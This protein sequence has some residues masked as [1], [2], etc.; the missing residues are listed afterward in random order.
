MLAVVLLYLLPL[1]GLSLASNF[2]LNF[3]FYDFYWIFYHWLPNDKLDFQMHR[4]QK[5]RTVKYHFCFEQFVLNFSENFLTTSVGQVVTHVWG[6]TSFTTKLKMKTF[7]EFLLQQNKCRG[8]TAYTTGKFASGV[9]SSTC[10]KYSFKHQ[11]PNCTKKDCQVIVEKCWS[12]C[13]AVVFQWLC[14][15]RCELK[16]DEIDPRRQSYKK[17][18]FS[19]DWSNFTYIPWWCVTALWR[20]F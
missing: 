13:C 1:L 15:I 2:E 4:F 10:L 12:T 16:F 7:K 19:E 17:N 18:I 3:T 14:T 11:D 5:Q 20:V 8:H 6:V 9:N